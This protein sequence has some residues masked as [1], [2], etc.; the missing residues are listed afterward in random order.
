MAKSK[1]AF[2]LL[3]VVVVI[4]LLAV[5]ASFVVPLSG[6]TSK[7]EALEIFARDL[8]SRLYVIQSN[9]YAGSGNCDYQVIFGSN[10]YQVICNS[11]VISYEYPPKVLAVGPNFSGID[12]TTLV[13]K[14]G[15]VV[16]ENQGYVNIENL[17]YVSISEEGLI[18]YGDNP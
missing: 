6:R 1:S 11:E 10:G 12:N 16:P 3:E 15:S 2:T 14:K 7:N 5:T 8:V 17:Y 9:A 13:F 4:A 18:E